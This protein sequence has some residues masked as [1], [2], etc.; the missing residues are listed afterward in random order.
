VIA[1]KGKHSQKEVLKKLARAVAVVA[2]PMELAFFNYSKMPLAS[3][4]WH[5]E[6]VGVGV[7]P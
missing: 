4:D 2:A 6:V 3:F 7:V 1:T 5:V